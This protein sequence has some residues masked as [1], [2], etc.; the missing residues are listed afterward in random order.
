MGCGMMR[1]MS[2]GFKVFLPVLVGFLASFVFARTDV[3]LLVGSDLHYTEYDSNSV[4]CRL[5]IQWMNALP[6]KSYPAAVGGGVI[7]TPDAVVLCGD[8]TNDATQP[9]WDRWAADWGINGERLIKYPVFEGF[10]NHDG[11][12]ASFVREAIK[13][14]NPA[15]RWLAGVSANGLHYS[16]D[17]DGVHFVQTNLYT[18]NDGDPA[19]FN[20]TWNKPEKSLDFLISDLQQNVGTTGKPVVIFQHYG[21][22]DFSINAWGNGGWWSAAERTAF[23]NAVS[24][25]NVIGVFWGH[26]HA[27]AFQKWNNTID[28]YN[29]RSLNIGPTAPGECLVVHITDS[30]MVIGHRLS[31]SWG[32]TQR[33]TIRM[34]VV[35]VAD[36]GKKSLPHNAGSITICSAGGIHTFALTNCAGTVAIVIMTLR[37]EKIHLIPVADN[38]A[39][40]DGTTLSG[41][42]AAPGA[43]IAL[44]KGGTVSM[45]GK[46]TIGY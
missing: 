39:R 33:K 12:P 3:T 18:G 40:W 7:D 30:A 8:L 45:Q 36:A 26:S 24:T 1:K 17:I 35:A 9:Q 23:Y 41:H 32:I 37:G 16:W 44:T 20:N 43:Y 14:R 13:A 25:Y 38:H 22:D 42:R 10:G 4:S 5:A 11:G 46:F 15:R 2:I 29:D 27:A 28:V 34:P 6:G 31:N 19:N 21:W